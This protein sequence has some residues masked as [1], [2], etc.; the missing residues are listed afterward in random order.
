[1]SSTQ[2]HVAWLEAKADKYAEDAKVFTE[3]RSSDIQVGGLTG[4]QWATVY[5][6]VAHEL[7]ECAREADERRSRTWW[8]RA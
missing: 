4:E 2:H 6:A 8:R 5:K 3:A 7:R 1:M